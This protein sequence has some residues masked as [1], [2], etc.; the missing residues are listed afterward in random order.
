MKVGMGTNW[1]KA[2]SQ[3][4]GV[5]DMQEFR[6]P[7]F[8]SDGNNKSSVDVY[9]FGKLMNFV[10]NSRGVILNTN[11]HLQVQKLINQCTSC[12][13]TDRPNWNH[14]ISVMIGDAFDFKVIDI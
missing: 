3:D 4:S 11:F 14:I 10:L 5:K 9:S 7:E 8:K 1:M 13:P 2:E 12:N 6:A